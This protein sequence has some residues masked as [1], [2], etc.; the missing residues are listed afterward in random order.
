MQKIVVLDKI[1]FT[2]GDIDLSYLDALGDVSYYD[3]LP[4][5][6]VVKVCKDAEIIICNKTTFDKEKITKLK[7]LKYIGLT[8]TG[9]NNV[10]LEYAKNMGI[11]VTN[12]PS[13]STD[14]VAQH[15]FAFILH[16]ANKV[17]Q[18]D[19]T[20]KDGEW[21]KSKT[22]CYFY[23]PL[24]EIANKTLG[25]IGYGDIGK[26]VAKIASAFSMNV[27]VYTR[28]KKDMPYKQVTL[29]EVFKKSDFL[30]LHCPL[31]EQTKGIVNEKT[32][33]LMKPSS[34]LINTSRGG[35]IDEQALRKALDDGVIAHAMLDVLQ[36]E[37][38]SKDCP[39]I[40]LDNVTFTPH[41]AWAPK[42][43]RQRLIIE[44]AKNVERYVSG[45]PQN[46]V[47]K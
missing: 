47:N 21:Q 2:N 30:T 43:C 46:V 9:Y 29:E 41:V 24:I 7:K 27:I 10:D 22:F 40:G 28:T 13:Y 3:V 4:N 38:M 16:Y 26:K 14:D 36:S 19:K 35:V 37:P 25:I 15:V 11:T 12:V 18:Y 8:A 6:E 17:H 44:V 5:D 32:L 42:E 39:L 1:S 31:N 33:S 34:V 23:K 45:V 20:V